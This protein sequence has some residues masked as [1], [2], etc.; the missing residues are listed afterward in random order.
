MALQPFGYYKPQVRAHAA[1]GRQDV[2]RPLRRRLRP[3]D[4]DRHRRS[5]DH[6][7]RGGRVRAS[8]SIE[9]RFPR[10]A[11]R[12]AP[13]SGL[14]GRQEGAERPRRRGGL[15]RRRL[16][17]EPGAR[18]PRALPG[19]R[20]PAFQHR[21]ALPLRPG[22]LP[23]GRP[24]RPAADRLHQVHARRAARRQQGAEAPERPLGQPLLEPRRGGDPA[25]PGREPRGADRRQPGAGQDH[26]L[27]RRR[28]LR[29][30]H[31]PAGE[32]DLR[33][34]AAQPA[35]GTAAQVPASVS[36]IE[37]SF[38]S[39][40]IIPGAFPRTD[41]LSFN[42]AYDRQI[43]HTLESKTGLVGAQYTQLRGGWNE[44]YALNFQR[45]NY[46]VGLD[47]GTSNLL[48][49]S[50][51][52]ERVQADDRI[53]TTNGYRLRFT[54]QGAE[55]SALSDA[56][57]VQGLVDGK[58]IRTVGEQQPADRPHPDR[59]HRHQRLPHAPAALPLLRRRRPERAR[60][61][62]RDRSAPRTRPAT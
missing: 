8:A 37:Q 50:A 60:L 19:R 36:Q 24:R 45:E 14:R 42:L 53:Y 10:P 12:R 31:R 41:N 38:L 15:S 52:L 29:H 51:G 39:S 33:P 55:K 21:P 1:P 46:K 44:T 26:A 2:D 59:L 35:R 11:G 54:L 25:G 61:P 56:T 4:Q 43:T 47:T 40:Y 23:P 7:R 34:P 58:V 9:S 6:R 28:G 62:L 17:G 57:F 16:P 5:A 49:P 22:L 13:S 30:R 3:A 20:R 18:R 27:Q 48:V 32:G